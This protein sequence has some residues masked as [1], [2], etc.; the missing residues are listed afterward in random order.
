[1][2]IGTHQ[3]SVDGKG[4]V[5]I[6]AP[7]RA[8]LKGAEA[9]FVWRSFRGPYLEGGGPELLAK[10]QAALEAKGPFDAARD[11]LEYA[12]F[13]EARELKLDETGRCSLPEELRA[14][15]GLD[16]K[17]AFAGLADRF[18]IWAPEALEARAAAARAK[19]LDARKA[20]T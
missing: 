17:A 6:P 19:A 20:G 16:G 10:Y 3:S 12:I 14:H 5:S 9:V 4:R 2:F 11:D 8:A 13:A 15:A 18:E 1:M 7:F